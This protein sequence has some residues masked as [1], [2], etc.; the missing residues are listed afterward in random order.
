VG[1][2]G[3]GDWRGEVRRGEVGGVEGEGGGME[4]EGGMV[5]GE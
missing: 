2:G 3:Q 5:R 4:G 1:G